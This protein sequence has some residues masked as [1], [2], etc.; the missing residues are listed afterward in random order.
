VNFSGSGMSEVKELQVTLPTASR[1]C[2]FPS[3]SPI[4]R[5]RTDG[6]GLKIENLKGARVRA[7][8][9]FKSSILNLQA[10][11]FLT[12]FPR[13]RMIR[14]ETITRA[15]VTRHACNLQRFAA[16]AAPPGQTTEAGGAF[17]KIEGREALLRSVEL[18]LNRDNVKQI[19]IV[20]SPT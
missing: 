7:P 12:R 11:R 1:N 6:R 14:L 8:V 3:S 5:C 10:S 15:G 13:R 16:D 19:Q 18:F 2:A 9:P 17:V 4:Y 20:F